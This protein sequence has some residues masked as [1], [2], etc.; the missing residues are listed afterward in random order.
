MLKTALLSANSDNTIFD[1]V[2]C[3]SEVKI[4]QKTECPPVSLNYAIAS[5]SRLVKT[6]REASEM[7][8]SLERMD[9]KVSSNFR[10]CLALQ[11]EISKSFSCFSEIAKKDLPASTIDSFGLQVRKLEKSVLV[12][13]VELYSWNFSVKQKFFKLFR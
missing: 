2:I 8:E 3:D 1:D 7:I 4:G 6:I 11:S 9:K 5:H 12:A 10:T 13:Q